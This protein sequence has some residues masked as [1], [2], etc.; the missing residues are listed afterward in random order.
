MYG[1]YQACNRRRVVLPTPYTPRLRGKAGAREGVTRMQRTKRAIRTHLGLAEQAVEWT[2][3]FHPAGP[4][5]EVDDGGEDRSIW[6]RNGHNSGSR[7]PIS[8]H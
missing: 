3:V 5:D 1:E 4:A 2:D 7:A 6:W 8:I